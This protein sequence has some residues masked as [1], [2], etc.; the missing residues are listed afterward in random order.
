MTKIEPGWY[1]DPADHAVQRYWDGSAWVGKP[2]PADA[3]P[4]DEPEPADPAPEPEPA[5]RSPAERPVGPNPAGFPDGPPQIIQR[6]PGMT[7]PPDTVPIRSLGITVGWLANKDVDR[8]L[9]GR[10]LAHPGMRFVARLVD[11][12]CLLGLNALVNGYFV[13]QFLEALWPSVREAARSGGGAEVRIPD[14]VSEHYWIVV[15]IGLGLW[16]AY[17][18]PATLNSGQTLGKRLMGIRVEPL[19]PLRF[20][21]GR[22]F[23]RWSY[24]GFLMV[25]FP[26]G[27]LFW[28]MDGIWCIR[29]RPFRQCLHD[30]SPGTIVVEV[31]REKES[32]R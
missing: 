32:E 24:M 15:L 25:C 31:P 10:T 2:V 20:G 1:P 9:A 22:M 13:W 30:K 4:P 12:V 29:D 19:G 5:T 21:W 16:F 17:E 18:V 28:L 14:S 3:E 27:L 8:I 23:L 26:F 6:Q 11:A 7:Q